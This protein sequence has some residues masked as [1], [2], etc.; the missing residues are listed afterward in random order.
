MWKRTLFTVAVAT[1]CASAVLAADGSK[2]LTPPGLDPNA[3]GLKT[4]ATLRP[5]RVSIAEADATTASFAETTQSTTTNDSPAPPKRAR[6]KPAIT[7]QVTIARLPEKSPAASSRRKMSSSAHSA[8]EENTDK[9]IT[10]HPVEVVPLPEN[11]LSAAGQRKRQQS[12]LGDGYR[13]ATEAASGEVQYPVIPA[14]PIDGESTAEFE[15]EYAPIVSADDEE[16][17]APIISAADMPRPGRVQ[18]TNSEERTQPD[19]SLPPPPAMPSAPRVAAQQ[20]QGKPQAKEPS[21]LSS[22]LSGLRLP[23]FRP[24]SSK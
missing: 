17:L 6:R 19:L 14:D 21:R 24:R 15:E 13:S 5:A 3:S 11:S 9:R 23:E 8:S 4:P 7:K 18:A 2:L 1:C 20:D 22:V 16:N 10:F 12:S